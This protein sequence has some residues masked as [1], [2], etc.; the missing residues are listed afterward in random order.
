MEETIRED[1]LKSWLLNKIPKLKPYFEHEDKERSDDWNSYSLF[2]YVVNPFVK[3]L[4]SNKAF[5]E[6]KE[7][8]D[9][10]EALANYG[11]NAIKNEL[12]VAIE[13]LDE[14][15]HQ[16]WP[17]LG[18]TLKSNAKY[19]IT[20]YPL[21]KSKNSAINRHFRYEDYI[22][23]WEQE[24]R[25]IGGWHKLTVPH[26]L[27]IRYKLVKKF[28]IKGIVIYEP[29]GIEWKEANLPWPL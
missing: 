12:Q 9:L 21:A 18:L 28:D 5:E 6:I 14:E 22:E 25:M 1:D 2:S 27:L 13:E 11:D 8:F 20:W 23:R 24:V 10:L 17:F 26:L 16:L 29:G 15:L 3:N 19:R 4:L 7:I